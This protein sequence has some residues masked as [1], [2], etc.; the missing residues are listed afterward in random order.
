LKWKILYI[1]ALSALVPILLVYGALR[2]SLPRLDGSFS[3][4]GLADSVTIDRDALGIPTIHAANRVD[5]AYGTGFAHAQDR[6]FQMDVLRRLAA[7]ELAEIVG[8]SALK[9]DKSTRIFRFR[10]VAHEALQQETAQ[11]LAIL[12]AYTRGVNAGLASLHGRPWEYWVLRSKPQAWQREDS[13]LVIYAMWLDLQASGFKR[14]MLR[15]EINADLGGSQCNFGLKCALAFF[16]PSSSVWDAPDESGDG[17]LPD[18]T[19]GAGVPAADALNVRAALSSSPGAG[20]PPRAPAPGSNNWAVGGRFTSNGAALIANDM[21]LGLHVPTMWYR[22]RLRIE[23]STGARGLDLNG[24]TLPGTPMLVAGSN[25]DVAWG[26]TNTFG[27]WLDVEL[28]PCTSLGEH[29]IRTPSDSQPVSTEWEEIRIRGGS[30]VRLPVTTA[31]HGVLLEA[32]PDKKRCWFGT[33]LAQLPS[34][35]NLNLL[36]MERV[37]SV[38]AAL[39]LAPQVGIP[40]QNLVVGDREGHIGWTI[41]GRIPADTGST[42][43][44]GHSPWTTPEQHPRILDPQIGRIWTANARVTDELRAQQAIGRARGAEYALG[45]RAHQIRDDLLALKE[46]A[47]P[48]DMLRIQ[49]DDRAIFLSRWRDLLLEVLDSDSLADRPLRGEFK[50]LLASWNGRASTD[51]VGYRLVRTAHERIEAQVWQMI[52]STLGIPVSQ[53]TAPPLQFEESLWRLV[54]EQPLHMLAPQYES[55]RALLLAMVDSTITELDTKC[56]DLTRCSWGSRNYVRVRHPLSRALPFLSWLLDMPAIQLPGDD[57]MPRVQGEGFGA[58]ER[59][60]VSPGHEGEGYFELPGGQS[61]H[62]LSHYYRA[63]FLDWAR[64]NALPFLPGPA[65]HQLVLRPR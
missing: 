21:H 31:A 49:L 24:V 45:A 22:A 42:L 17:V 38:S 28:V 12:D 19:P 11:Q 39:D 4:T 18:G 29:E 14:E 61:G 47:T 27:H 7:G 62:P 50:R 25:G 16:Y 53:S 58:S 55:W 51:S 2:A 35:T 43:T 6:F 48:V 59:F 13:L 40:H 33:W 52:L 1:G 57:D 65:E 56:G 15:H 37:Q 10:H 63:G 36:Q 32:D 9:Q 8:D 5:L 64:G 44:D 26:F 23:E 34:A 46:P 30:S 41:F 3:D 60:A 54:N 20:V